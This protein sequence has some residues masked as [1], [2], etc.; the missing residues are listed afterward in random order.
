MEKR[1]RDRTW[2]AIGLCVCMLVVC[3]L[4]MLYYLRPA[5]LGSVSAQPP[6]DAFGMLLIDIADEEAAESYHVDSLGV[7]VLAVLQEGQAEQAGVNSGDRLTHVNNTPLDSTLQFLEMQ[8]TFAP[9]ERVVL[10]FLRG[11]D[12]LAHAVTLVWN[13]E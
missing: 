7:Y 8:E 5:W 11:T 1:T 12:D 4:G 2:L 10:E 6:S 3:L 13:A 9:Q